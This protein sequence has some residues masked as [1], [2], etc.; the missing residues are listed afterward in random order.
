[1]KALPARPTLAA[2]AALVCAAFLFL[3]V[4][5]LCAQNGDSRFVTGG[6]DSDAIEAAGEFRVGI[7]AY[8]R[9]AFNEAILSFERALSFRPGEAI[10]LDWLGR[11][12]YR[13]GLETGSDHDAVSG[14]FA[15]MSAVYIHPAALEEI[16]ARKER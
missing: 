16:A 2:C 15:S 4:P 1:M 5:P 9:Y 8:N 10:I 6:N 7:Q 11:A 13:S 14:N 3:P 12:Y